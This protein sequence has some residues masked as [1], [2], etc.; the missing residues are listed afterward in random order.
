MYSLT[1]EYNN[2]L[3]S[4]EAHFEPASHFL[5][6]NPMKKSVFWGSSLKRIGYEISEV[7]NL[8]FFA[9]NKAAIKLAINLMNHHRVKYNNI[10]YLK[11]HK[12]IKDELLELDYI[13]TAQ[14]VADGL[15]KALTLT[16]HE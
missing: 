4:N 1:Y 5:S 14:M 8:L 2:T 3:A 15:T 13:L 9:D 7:D 12:L 11:V 10:Q 6:P 16:K